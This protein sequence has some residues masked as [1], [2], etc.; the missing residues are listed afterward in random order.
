MRRTLALAALLSVVAS[1]TVNA[2]TTD[3]FLYFTEWFSS[4]TAGLYDVDANGKVLKP[5]VPMIVRHFPPL[6]L[7]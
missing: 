4:V 3:T 1:G 5:I 6:L 7:L 2:Q